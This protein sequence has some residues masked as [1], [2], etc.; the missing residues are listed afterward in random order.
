[1]FL[2]LICLFFEGLGFILLFLLNVLVVFSP[3]KTLK[4]R[5]P[6]GTDPGLELPKEQT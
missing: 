4:Q 3:R 5:L 6:P 1:M 2:W